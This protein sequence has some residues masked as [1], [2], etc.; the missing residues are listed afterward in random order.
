MTLV[1]VGLSPHE[2]LH[3]DTCRTFEV[4]CEVLLICLR[5]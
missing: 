5:L 4:A 1:F 2:K 3:M